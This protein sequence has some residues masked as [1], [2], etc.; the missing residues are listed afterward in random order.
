MAQGPRKVEG[1]N[2]SEATSK[3]LVLGC[4]FGIPFWKS[5]LV[6]VE[7]GFHIFWV[8]YGLLYFG[9]LPKVYWVSGVAWK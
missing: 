8:S 1:T 4:L 6:K 2:R 9:K 7:G 3:G 5:F